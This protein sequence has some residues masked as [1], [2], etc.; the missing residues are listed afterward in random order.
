GH[1]PC[2]PRCLRSRAARPAQSGAVPPLPPPPGRRRRR[3]RPPQSGRL[4]ALTSP[5]NPLS[6][7]RGGVFTRGN[8]HRFPLSTR[9]RGGQGVRQT[10]GHQLSSTGRCRTLVIGPRTPGNFYVSLVLR[11]G[12][13]GLTVDP[14]RERVS[15]RLALRS[16]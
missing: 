15:A 6:N 5:P 2:R 8:E 12:V 7:W 11:V 14:L 13:S 10:A 16:A 4:L 9:W 1:A 3:S